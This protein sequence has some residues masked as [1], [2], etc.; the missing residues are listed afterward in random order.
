MRTTLMIAIVLAA[1]CQSKPRPSRSDHDAADY[2][3]FKY[4]QAEIEKAVSSIRVGMAYADLV[5][6]LRDL[7]G[8]AAVVLV[9]ES[10]S[11][12]NAYY[13]YELTNYTGGYTAEAT[14]SFMIRWRVAPM[15]DGVVTQFT[16]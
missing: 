15:A 8:V 2:E 16:R 12:T 13:I 1:A 3:Q 10:V 5:S 14:I 7:Q 6:T 9:T 4:A 11:A